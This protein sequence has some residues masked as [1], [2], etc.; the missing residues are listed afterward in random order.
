MLARELGQENVVEGRPEMVAEDFGEFGKAA[1]V[2]SVLL[3]IGAVEPAKHASAKASGTPLPS[4]HS[5]TFAPDREPTIRTGA[6]VLALSAL[7]LFDK[8]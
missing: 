1:G 4:L 5:A 6:T 8:R 2:P 7:E 3:R